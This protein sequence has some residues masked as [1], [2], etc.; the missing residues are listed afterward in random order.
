MQE[1]LADWKDELEWEAVDSTPDMVIGD[2][3]LAEQRRLREERLKVEE[4]DHKL[5]EEL[6]SNSI[7]ENEV[8]IKLKEGGNKIIEKIK[9]SGKHAVK[10]VI[11]Q[12]KTKFTKKK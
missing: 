9:T 1:E 8:F 10:K 2:P 11:T 4:A 6:F 5:T 7:I 3:I 12:G